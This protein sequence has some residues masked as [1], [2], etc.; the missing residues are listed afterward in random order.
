[1]L[2]AAFWG[3]A[4]AIVYTHAGYPAILRLLSR[5]R[6]TYEETGLPR[7]SLIIA[8]YDEEEVIAAKVRNVLG[9]DYPRDRL[10]LIVCSDGSSDG[11]VA[12]AREA[13][14]P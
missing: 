7:I 2:R 14:L 12:R 11:T 9:L 13:G 5:G 6:T 4:L 1:M 8:A 3:S 10:E